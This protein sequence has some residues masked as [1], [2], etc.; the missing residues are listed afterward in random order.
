LPGE[1]NDKDATSGNTATDNALLL[2][3]DPRLVAAL[4]TALS[5]EDLRIWAGMP[6]PRRVTALQRIKVLDQY[7]AEPG[8][9]TAQRAAMDA[10]VTL[11]R[12][13]QMARI[14]PEKRLLSSLGTYALVTKPRAGLKPHQKS[15]LQAVVKQVVEAEANQGDS[16]AALARKLGQASKL[17]ADDVPSKNTLRV[18]IESEQRRLRETSLAG[19]EILF[20]L[21]ATSL[22]RGDGLPH[23]VFL[24]IDGGTSLILGHAIGL[25]E[26]SAAGYRTAAGV[27]L[28]HI[29]A[30]L[31][32]KNIWS[33]KMERSRIVPGA[34]ASDIGAISSK[35]ALRM[36]DVS[37]KLTAVDAQGEYIR[38]HLGL[39]LGYVRLFPSRTI[40]TEASA[41]EIKGVELDTATAFA[42]VSVAVAEH[43]A[44]LVEALELDGDADPPGELMRLLEMMA[45]S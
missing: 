11:S 20:D 36:G 34:D 39:R 42:R 4:G 26:E 44:T 30:V 12:F 6:E 13:Y 31:Q 29:P 15:A 5:L 2:D 22:P 17:P 32:G 8:E 1:R 7:C 35:I 27:C 43:N 3:A 21:S 28:S 41:N 38:H 25:A 18:F 23:V 19:R 14:W 9:I 10:G 40:L 37:P 24:V 45:A 33:E 16:I